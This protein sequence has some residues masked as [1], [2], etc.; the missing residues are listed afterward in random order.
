MLSFEKEVTGFYLSGHPLEEQQEMLK[1]NITKTTLDFAVSEDTGNALVEDGE[2]EIIGGM[3][4]EKTTKLT[5]TNSMMAFL[6]IEDLAGTVEV[7]VFPRDYE[8]LREKLIEENKVFIKGKVTV[9]EEKPAKLILQELI[10]FDEIPKELWVQYPSIEEYRAKEQELF[11][12]LSISDGNDR[13][14]IYCQKEKKRKL[15]PRSCNI[16]LS[17]RL[18]DELS[19]LCGKENIAVIEKSIEK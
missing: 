12:F 7:L 10:P 17:S 11:K 15:L 1:K 4:I 16:H 13:V 6:T 3:I 19:H 2:I 5:R 8:R 14:V 9:E 18:L